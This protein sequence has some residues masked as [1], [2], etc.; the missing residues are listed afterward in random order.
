[1]LAY[2]YLGVFYNPEEAVEHCCHVSEQVHPAS[3]W[4]EYFDRKF[5]TYETTVQTCKALF[6]KMM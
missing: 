3:E 1:M 2:E 5:E 6:P 4:R